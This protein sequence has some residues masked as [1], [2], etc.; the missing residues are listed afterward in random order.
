[1]D[2][3]HYISGVDIHIRLFLAYTAKVYLSLAIALFSVG[4]LRSDILISCL[5]I[6]KYTLI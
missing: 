2:G 1:M 5:V 4:F 6:A 3:V